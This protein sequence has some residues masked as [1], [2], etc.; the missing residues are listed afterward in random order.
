MFPSF[1]LT[2][3]KLKP[4]CVGGGR[5]GSFSTNKSTVKPDVFPHSPSLSATPGA[6]E[7]TGFL[8]ST[9][10]GHGINAPVVDFVGFFK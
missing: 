8:S 2:R 6:T 7:P 10:D 1:N 3:S 4:F 5:S 9:V